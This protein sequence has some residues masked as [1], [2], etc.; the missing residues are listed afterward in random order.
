M[1]FAALG[2]IAPVAGALIQEV[3]D[4]A[5]IVNAHRASR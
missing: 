1:V 4:I 3:I 5:V 2:Y